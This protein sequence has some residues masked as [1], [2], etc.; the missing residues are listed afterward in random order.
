MRTRT[1]TLEIL[2]AQT[3]LNERTDCLE[4]QAAIGSHGY[5]STYHNGELYLAHRLAYELAHHVKLNSDDFICHT[6]DNKKCI[7]VDHLFLGDAMANVEDMRSKG[8]QHAKLTEDEVRKIKTLLANG[9]S[10]RRI[11]RRFGVNQSAIG[12][13]ST[14]KNWGWLS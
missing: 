6:C 10:Q 13:I 11:A 7:N 3:T 12:H 1:K 8:R 4:W 2:Y 5:G 9:V 14:G